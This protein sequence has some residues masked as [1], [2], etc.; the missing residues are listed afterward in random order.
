MLLF[1]F[2]SACVCAGV[3]GVVSFVVTGFVSGTVVSMLWG[4]CLPGCISVCVRLLS[5]W[6]WF[7][8]VVAALQVCLWVALG[9]PHGMVALSGLT[10]LVIVCQCGMLTLVVVCLGARAECNWAK[11]SQQ[12][13]S[14]RF[15]VGCWRA[16][17]AFVRCWGRCVCI[18]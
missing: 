9:G 13:A 16:P 12:A 5:S 14:L 3:S 18:P 6:C 15:C 8:V 1:L 7:V 11:S 17:I 2:A 4:S 10:L